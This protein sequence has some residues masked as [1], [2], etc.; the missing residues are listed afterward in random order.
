MKFVPV[1]VG[2][3]VFPAGLKEEDKNTKATV[4]TMTK[5]IIKRIKF[6]LDMN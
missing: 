6:L 1:S 4:A 2:A 3:P 5:T